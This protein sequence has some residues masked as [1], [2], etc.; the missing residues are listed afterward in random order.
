MSSF[1]KPF[2]AA[3]LACVAAW[4]LAVP[5][6]SAQVPPTH[7]VLRPTFQS[8]RTPSPRPN[9]RVKRQPHWCEPH[10]RHHDRHPHHHRHHHHL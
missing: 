6:V 7:P 4:A 3:I 8:R 5:P 1:G 10:P 9:P 2:G